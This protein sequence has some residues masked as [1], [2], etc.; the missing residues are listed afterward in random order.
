MCKQRLCEGL[1]L[2]MKILEAIKYGI[3]LLFWGSLYAGILAFEKVEAV[4]YG[5]KTAWDEAFGTEPSRCERGGH[6]KNYEHVDIRSKLAR[7]ENI[8]EIIKKEAV[9]V[10]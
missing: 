4:I 7:G 8:I 2:K 9:E 6:Y 1:L 5:K 3:G 10:R